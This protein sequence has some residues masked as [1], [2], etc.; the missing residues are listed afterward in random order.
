MR[1]CDRCSCSMFV[2]AVMHCTYPGSARWRLGTLYRTVPIFHTYFMRPLKITLATCLSYLAVVILATFF[3]IK[4]M[5]ERH[6]CLKF[7]L[8][9]FCKY[10]FLLF[11]SCFVFKTFW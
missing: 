9:I 7:Y 1:T 10:V 3:M 4:F 6:F 8:L 2:D 11:N 5:T